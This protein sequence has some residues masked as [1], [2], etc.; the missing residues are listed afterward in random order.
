MSVTPEEVNKGPHGG[1]YRN[2]NNALEIG[3]YV[4][5]NEATSVTA[6]MMAAMPGQDNRGSI[7]GSQEQISDATMGGGN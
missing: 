3:G 4:H 7:G 1:S 6:E 2:S 5:P